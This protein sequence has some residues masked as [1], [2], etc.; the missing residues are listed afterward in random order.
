MEQWKVNRERDC[1]INYL[2][3]YLKDG[4]EQ[5]ILIHLEVQGK[6]EE[7]FPKRMFTYGYRIFFFG[8]RVSCSKIF[9]CSNLVIEV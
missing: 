8:Y 5:W 6:K 3:F 9:F 7:D 4:K 2:K 1:L